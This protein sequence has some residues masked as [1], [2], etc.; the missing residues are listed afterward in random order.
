MGGLITLAKLRESG[1]LLGLYHLSWKHAIFILKKKSL[2][3][4]QQFSFIGLFKSL[5]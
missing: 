2:D 3:N 1:V 5:D 4:R